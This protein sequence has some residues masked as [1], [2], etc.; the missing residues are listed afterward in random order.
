MVWFSERKELE[1]QYYEWIKENGIADQPNS[2]IAF[3]EING[4]LKDEKIHEKVGVVK[5]K[6]TN[7]DKITESVENLA[8][9]L[10]PRIICADCPYWKNRNCVA[11]LPCEEALQ[12]WLQKECD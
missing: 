2:V 8:E 3:L 7:F 12:E 4:L 10:A 1:K 11:S 6:P 5:S 9:F